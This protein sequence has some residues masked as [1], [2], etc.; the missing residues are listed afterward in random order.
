MDQAGH[1]ITPETARSFLLP[2]LPPPRS[3]SVS[4]CP[5]DHYSLRLDVDADDWGQEGVGLYTFK[6]TD[7]KSLRR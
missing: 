3:L 6:V 4:Q 1:M 5:G 2:L 7:A